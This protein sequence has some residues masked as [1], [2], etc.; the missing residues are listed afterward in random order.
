MNISRSYRSTVRACLEK[1]TDLVMNEE[2]DDDKTKYENYITIFYN[3]E[4]VWHICE[5]L[6]IDPAPSNIIVQQ[7]LEWIRFHFPAPQRIAAALFQY[8]RE[9]NKNPDYW[10]AVKQLILQGQISIVRPLLH[11]HSSSDSI[12]FQTADQILKE[13]PI[14]TPYSGLSLQTFKSKF[15]NWVTET[16]Y[17]INAGVLDS[18]PDLED[19]IKL[20]TGNLATW[21]K[22][23]KD[24]SC[25]YE[26][27]PGLLNYTEPGCKHFELGKFAKGWMENWKMAK[28]LKDSG[29]NFLDRVILSVME[30]DMSQVLHDLQNM[31]DNQWFV[32]HITDL[33][34]HSGQLKVS[35]SEMHETELRDSLLFDF[36][37]TLMSKDSLWVFG[38]DY[39]EF[40]SKE[41]PAA[42]ELLLTKIPIKTEKQA[43]KIIAVA[44]SKGLL[45]VETEICRV[46]AAKSLLEKRNGNAL[47]WALRSQDYILV[48]G[49]ANTFLDV[50]LI[51]V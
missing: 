11:L 51:L 22:Q 44:R 30:N 15:Q 41:G 23:A 12:T 3:I 39:L 43:Q 29:L 21:R 38:L 1:L 27:L 32:A 13:M 40:S 48:T 28:G 19:V 50:S 47:E 8:G 33:L 34:H 35:S 5:I 26:Y 49:I 6:L 42:M 46:M 45:S 16:D 25:W 10:S 9:A 24:S 36:G 17:K 4:C 2:N 31:N 37:T 20:A 18:Q 14:F 7:L